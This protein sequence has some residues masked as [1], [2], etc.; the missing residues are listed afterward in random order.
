MAQLTLEIRAD[1]EV[2]VYLPHIL[3]V[4]ALMI[5]LFS[6]KPWKQPF[7]LLSEVACKLGVVSFA[8]IV[9]PRLIYFEISQPATSIT[10]F[11]YTTRFSRNTLFPFQ[12]GLWS[13]ID[14]IALQK[15]KFLHVFQKAAVFYLEPIQFFNFF[16]A[17]NLISHLNVRNMT[18]SCRHT[19]LPLLE[20]LSSLYYLLF[21]TQSNIEISER[22]WLWILYQIH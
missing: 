21:L 3:V 5:S 2:V 9:R 1:P 11:F 22:V 8:L 13:A 14:V 4:E 16:Q 7:L 6:F 18:E 10:F 15:T 19:N 20:F 12:L 17:N